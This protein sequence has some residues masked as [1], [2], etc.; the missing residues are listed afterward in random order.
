SYARGDS[1]KVNKMCGDYLKIKG[2]GG[3]I[4]GHWVSKEEVIAPE[5]EFPITTDQIEEIFPNTDEERVKEVVETINELSNEFGLTNKDRMAHF[6]AQIG[7]ET[8]GLEDLDESSY[9]S[10]RRVV[11]LFGL[12]KYADLF[13]N[14]DSNPNECVGVTYEDDGG[15]L[16][17][18]RPGQV[19]PT[20]SYNTKLAI[21]QAYGHPTEGITIVN[22]KEKV[23]DKNYNAGTLKVKTK[24]YG[25]DA[26]LFDVTYACRMGNAGPSSGH[27]STYK[28]KGFIHLTGRYQ[29]KKVSEAWNK[30]YPDDKKYFYK[31]KS[32]GGHL[33]ELTSDVEVAM[34]ASLIFWE[35]E[36]L[37]KGF[38]L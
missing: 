23:T 22:F 6:L 3:N 16:G 14:Y 1:I 5:P 27:G 7:A 38:L 34:K 20:F 31:K 19:S 2:V 15:T 8:D 12:S 30:K 28:G 11:E 13:Q 33:E 24:Y 26:K 9:Y 17:E 4:A 36:K 18:G 35:K 37:I 32:E 21:Y 29:Y 10:P 25:S